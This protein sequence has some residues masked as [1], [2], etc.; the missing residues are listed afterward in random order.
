[1]NAHDPRSFAEVKRIGQARKV[2]LG[3]QL[4]GESAAPVDRDWAAILVPHSDRLRWRAPAVGERDL[5]AADGSC[6]VSLRL[7]LILPGGIQSRR[8]ELRSPKGTYRVRPEG[9]PWS[10]LNHPRKTQRRLT[11]LNG[12]EVLRWGCVFEGNFVTNTPVVTV[13]GK[14]FLFDLRLD[15]RTALMDAL[16]VG[17]STRPL[18]RYRRVRPWGA[19]FHDRPYLGV[20]IAVSPEAML[21]PHLELLL[22]ISSSFMNGLWTPQGGG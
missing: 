17:G 19:V 18:V 21:I 22:A 7:P 15:G 11:D 2:R 9:S 10:Q 13:D 14:T 5:I 8:S 20:D 4:G 3:K 6:L 12:N 16:E 1:M